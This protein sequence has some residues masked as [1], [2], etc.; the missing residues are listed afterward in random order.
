MHGQINSKGDYH[1]AHNHLQSYLSGTY[2]LKVPSTQKNITNR[3]DVC[4]NHI[5]FYYPR[6]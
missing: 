5:T 2:Y 6:P 4:P 3:S 1:D